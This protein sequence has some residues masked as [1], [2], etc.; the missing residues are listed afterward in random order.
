[1]RLSRV[2]L[3]SVAGMVV[4]SLSVCA[5]TPASAHRETAQGA[6]SELEVSITGSRFTAGSNLALEGRL[7]HAE[8][9]QGGRGRTFLMVEARAAD[10]HPE[11]RAPVNMALVIDRS[12]SMAGQRMRHAL[13]AA[14]GVVDR[15][16]DGDTLS[17]LSFSDDADVLVPPTIL[18]G[19]SRAQINTVLR[20]VEPVGDTCM[21]CGVETAMSTVMQQLGPA[22]QL[23]GVQ[24]M[25]VLSDGKANK[26]IRDTDGLR[27]LAESCRRRGVPVTTVGVGFDY[28]ELNL[29]ALAN[30]SNGRHHFVANESSLPAL[31]A[32]EAKSLAATVATSTDVTIELA[33]GVELVRVLD[34]QHER[35][36]TRS[37]TVP[38]GAL[39]AG[40]TKT[41]LLEVQVPTTETGAQAV[42][43][44]SIRYDDRVERARQHA[45]AALA[46]EI[47]PR[48]SALQSMDPWVAA[49][50]ER[51]RTSAVLE[52]ANRLIRQGRAADARDRLEAQS[53]RLSDTAAK[54]KAAATERGDSR[55][56]DI[57]GDFDN[58]LRATT[59]AG[60][61]VKAKP[62]S[63]AKCGC[64]ASDI[65]CH[66]RCS[67]KDNQ[68][69]AFEMRE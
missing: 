47:T 13:A 38:L 51:S 31:F 29:A 41:V 64:S 21:S 43:T 52:D 61:S 26:G 50:I 32:E 12:G 14:R 49:R 63:P 5:L 20:R 8:L 67:Q 48:G 46:V 58:Q 66:M 54:A 24:Q 11:E 55:S 44:V 25:I 33:E 19:S 3:L 62:K 59:R 37:V 7:G 30:S 39:S 10:V 34:R 22:Q 17:V 60:G 4:S 2:V 1:M 69:D 65:S 56:S 28:N 45:A 27:R 9:P 16:A 35:L 15:L 53:R 18:G 68:A 57:D 36:G 40:Q 23:K 6:L 42:A